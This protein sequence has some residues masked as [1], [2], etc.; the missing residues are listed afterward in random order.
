MID[1]F[2]AANSIPLSRDAVATLAPEN[3]AALTL[4]LRPGVQLI[5]LDWPV[6]TVRTA[7]DAEQTCEPPT[8][9]APRSILVWRPREQVRYRTVDPVEANALPLLDP[10]TTFAELCDHIACTGDEETTPA[11]AAGLLERW[12]ADAVLADTP[13]PA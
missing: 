1:A 9:R 11:I 2:D 5:G 8:E 12:L 6:E 3:F 7:L 4:R 10:G 13:P